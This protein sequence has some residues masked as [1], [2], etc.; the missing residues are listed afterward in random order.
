MSISLLTV[1]ANEAN[2]VSDNIAI[3]ISIISLVCS[4][5]F[6]L[7]T[8]WQNQ[9][10]KIVD[11]E[12]NY[13]TEIYQG[14]LC[15]KIPQARSSMKFLNRRLEGDQ[16][17]L[18]AIS[19]MRRDSAYFKY[20]DEEFYGDVTQQL[21]KVEDYVVQ[22]NN[23]PMI[24]DEEEKEFFRCLTAELQQLYRIISNRYHGKRK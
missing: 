22:V 24:G 8:Y 19:E 17:F 4:V 1:A 20:S 10:L 3:V 9:K 21:Q 15:K 7:I 11:L 6:S 5:G 14:F 18:D 16:D 23:H 13:F 12:A 2:G